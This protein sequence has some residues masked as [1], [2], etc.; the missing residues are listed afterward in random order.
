MKMIIVNIYQIN[1]SHYVHLASTFE[2]AVKWVLKH[3]QDWSEEKYCFIAYE[4][5][6]DKDDYCDDKNDNAWFIDIQGNMT[7]DNPLFKE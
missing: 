4:V 1:D 5:T 6:L 2:E 7:K 3:G